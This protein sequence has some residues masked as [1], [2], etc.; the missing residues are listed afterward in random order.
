MN[1]AILLNPSPAQFRERP[2]AGA[3]RAPGDLIALQASFLLGCALRLA[4]MR[5]YP[6][7]LGPTQ[8]YGIAAGLLLLSA[9]HFA[10]GL[11]P[12]YGL[13][14][15]DRLRLRMRTVFTV[16]SPLVFWDYLVQHGSWSRGV[17]LATAGFALVLPVIA[18]ALLI[19]WLTSRGYWGTPVLVVGSGQAGA[20]AADRLREQRYLGFVPASHGA[21]GIRVAIVAT[22]NLG[23]EQLTALVETL[24]YSTVI[25]MP[26]FSGLQSQW[27]TAVDLSGTLGLELRRNLLL[28]SNRALKRLFDIALALPLLFLCAPVIVLFVLWIKRVSPGAA[29][30]AQEREGQDGRTIRV[31]KLRTMHPDAYR[32]IAELSVQ[33]RTEWELGFKLRND[34]RVLPGVGALLRRSSVDELP[35]LWNVPRGEMSLV[36][37][38]P[39]PFYH[40]TRFESEFCRLRRKVLPGITGLWQVNGRGDGDTRSLDTDYIRN[41]SFWMDLHVL[42]CTVEAVWKGTGAH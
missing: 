12:G 13:S 37:P 10:N 18:D 3:V 7:E 32:R 21:E 23:N 24:P 20:E 26:A 31:W 29:F 34:P 11:Y 5:W 39:L 36:G 41:W 6:A 19:R 2:W 8:L 35:Q 14:P 28:R 17:L 16:L 38:R 33:Q 25:V 15:V 1:V 40:L 4:V 42:A 27:V 30:Y 22:P 9:A